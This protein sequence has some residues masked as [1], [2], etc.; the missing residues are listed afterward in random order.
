LKE[1]T[2]SVSVVDHLRQKFPGY[3]KHY[4]PLKESEVKNIFDIFEAEMKNELLSLAFKDFERIQTYIYLSP[5]FA[6]K[7]RVNAD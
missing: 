3:E 2:V 1:H 5:T 6:S 4:I 7:Y